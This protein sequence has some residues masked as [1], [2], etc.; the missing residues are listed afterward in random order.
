MTMFRLLALLTVASG[1]ITPKPIPYIEDIAEEDSCPAPPKTLDAQEFLGPTHSCTFCG[2]KLERGLPAGPETPFQHVSFENRAPEDVSLVEVTPAGTEHF[3]AT[4]APGDRT[5]LSAQRGS[6][7]RARDRRGAVL[8]EHMVGR[9]RLVAEPAAMTLV[10][11]RDARR[12]ALEK[13]KAIPPL[14]TVPGQ[15]QTAPDEF[16]FERTFV[17]HVGRKLDLYF[18]QE[19]TA[20]EM[21]V[22]SIDPFTDHTVATYWEH[23]W[24]VRDPATGLRAAQFKV[25][26]VIIQ[27]CAARARA[28]AERLR[29]PEPV[30]L[31]VVLPE[32]ETLTHA[33]ASWL[34]SLGNMFSHKL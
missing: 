22:A 30:E 14:P 24:V 3:H 7:W 15:M 32:N 1:I 21:L 4:L 11:D 8:V 10:D 29:L 27:D 23:A 28:R 34:T 16:R 19:D 17:N 13:A 20:S 18:F 26:S 2:S 25:P 33:P 6:L 9:V 12:Y 31:S 5:I